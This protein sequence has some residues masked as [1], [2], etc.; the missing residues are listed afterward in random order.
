MNCVT[1]ICISVPQFLWQLQE[2]VALPWGSHLHPTLQ[3]L[4]EGPAHHHPLFTR[5]WNSGNIEN[6]IRIKYIAFLMQTKHSNCIK[7]CWCCHK[8]NQVSLYSSESQWNHYHNWWIVHSASPLYVHTVFSYMKAVNCKNMPSIDCV[9][10][11]FFVLQPQ[12]FF[13]VTIVC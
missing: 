10:N 7:C 12:S 9:H 8:S 3:Q 11:I 6:N 13:P 2:G 5:Y 4:G 1:P